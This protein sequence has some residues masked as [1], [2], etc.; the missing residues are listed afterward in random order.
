MRPD[1]PLHHNAGGR[2]TVTDGALGAGCATEIG[3]VV[4][5]A[6][7]ATNTDHHKLK[8]ETILVGLW[9]SRHLIYEGSPTVLFS[10][11]A[12]ERDATVGE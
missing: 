1:E 6:E 2:L 3:L 4:G 8:C 9:E 10:H 11:I 7:A 12:E 5:T